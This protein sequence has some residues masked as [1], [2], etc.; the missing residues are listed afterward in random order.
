MSVRFGEFEFD[1]A[2]RELRSGMRVQRLQEQPFQ[3]LSVLVEKAGQVVTREE[4]HNRLWPSKVYYDLDH[5]LNNAITRLREVL[6]DSADRPR[7]VET[8]P[9]V[10]YRFVAPLIA[11]QAPEAP[12]RIGALE[13]P[14]PPAR[15]PSPG[16][17]FKA[18][19][20]TFT[21]AL[22]VV[23]IAATAYL[24]GHRTPADRIRSVAVL[25]F[26]DLS[27]NAG[28]DFFAE[29]MTDALITDLAKIGS[30][31]VISRT[32]AMHYKGVHDS[33]ATL[34][35]K[36][37]VDAVVEGSVVR[38]GTRVHVNVRLVRVPNEH[39]V[40]AQSYDRDLISVIS[41][42][43][44]LAEAVA[45]AVAA[46]ITPAE[47]GRIAHAHVP[48]PQAYDDYLR[49][50]HLVNQRNQEAELASIPFFE[51]AIAADPNFAAAYAGLA[52]AYRLL[53]DGVGMGLRADQSGPKALEAA[54]KA[55]ALD[56]QLTAAWIELSYCLDRRDP[57]VKTAL[58]RA[59]A[60]S[61]GDAWAHKRLADYLFDS[62]KP[63]AA[64]PEYE[65]S[66][67]L[68]PLNPSTNATYGETL[69]ATGR[70]EQG[71]AQLRKTVQM[72]PWALVPRFK[73][74]RACLDQGRYPEAIEQ[75]QKALQISPRSLPAQVGLAA[76]LALSGRTPQAESMLMT[77]IP[78]A[79]ALGHPS[80]VALLQVRLHHRAEALAWLQ[81]SIDVGDTDT[82]FNWSD[83]A[84]WLAADPD[85]QALARK[86][87]SSP[88][89]VAT[90]NSGPGA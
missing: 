32:T 18:H 16:S 24:N 25:P 13:S 78:Q 83:D 66:L 30:L 50:M 79:Q 38:S 26:E 62:G 1:Q 75:F 14:S 72:D 15:A 80:A 2:A 63:G 90:R 3:V 29:G 55:V 87:T 20:I 31:D 51:S 4:L 69:V 81:R 58:E 70:V 34:A 54:R 71:L 40:W 27:A 47:R 77:I 85:F 39:H 60:L 36:L 6:R 68:D 64:L 52:L 45:G 89:P 9:R 10:G 8:I 21:A 43:S 35:T 86:V 22:V 33:L 49:G 59:L 41:L 67:R 11:P 12:P 5:G 19:W 23:G 76:A 28:Q 48:P 74:G 42:Q 53:A 17:S 37:N 46:A 65:L 61:P 56:P 82:F 84:D 88:T 7:Y 73:L 44:E 57:Q